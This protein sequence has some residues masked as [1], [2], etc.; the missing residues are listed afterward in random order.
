MTDR[1]RR[2]DHPQVHETPANRLILRGSSG[3]G[4]NRTRGVFPP[5]R[6]AETA[7]F[8]GISR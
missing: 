2:D 8:A 7:R 1:S 4:G 6:A 3:D 5:W